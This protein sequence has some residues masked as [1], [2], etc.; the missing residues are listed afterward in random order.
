M[1]EET[2][3]F[4]TF[5]P[6][7][8]VRSSGDGRTVVGIAVPY[9]RE[10]RINASLTESFT[11]GAFAHQAKAAHR[12]PFTRDHMSHGG[13]LIG[14]TTLLRED[15]AGLYGEWRVSKTPT[16][17]ETIELVRDGA[18]DQLSI[19]FR[20]V[21]S[22]NTRKPNGTVVRTKAHLTE[23]A[24]VMDGA[25]GDGAVVTGMRHADPMA[26]SE[27]GQLLGVEPEAGRLRQAEQVLASL[28]LLDL[29][30]ERSQSNLDNTP[31]GRKLW[32]YYLHDPE[33]SAWIHAVHPW[34]TLRNDLVA[35][36]KGDLSKRQ[37]DGLASNLFH[38]HFGYWP[39]SRK[40][41]NP[42]GPG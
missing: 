33:G 16:G 4:R 27:C 2:E 12:V 21:A 13:K 28:P 19:G 39:G 18:L 14:K 35:N 29:D 32:D 3:Q 26:C 10:Q 23:V 36:A 24:V 25:Y 1:A 20:E 38:A 22:G 15:A 5:E 34:T 8:E 9:D 37:A 11:R 40:G 31:N 17:D 30:G 42:V 41:D 6:D 7:L